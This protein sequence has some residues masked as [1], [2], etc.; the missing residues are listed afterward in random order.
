ME[1]VRLPSSHVRAR[2][3]RLWIEVRGRGRPRTGLVGHL[4]TAIDV[5]IPDPEATSPEGFEPWAVC[6]VHEGALLVLPSAAAPALCEADVA[7]SRGRAVVVAA[8]VVAISLLAPPAQASPRGTTDGGGTTAV[9]ASSSPEHVEAP[10]ETSEPEPSTASPNTPT[11]GDQAPASAATP[12][13]SGGTAAVPDAAL[14]NLVGHDVFATTAQGVVAGRIVAFDGTTVSLTLVNGQVAA[15]PRVQLFGVKLDI[16]SKGKQRDW[17]PG[18]G[19]EI[20]GG[21]LTTMGVGGLIAGFVLIGTSYSSVEY[22]L[23]AM[24]AGVASLG[25]GVPLLVVG[26]QKRKRALG[27]LK[28]K[29]ATLTPAPMRTRGGGWGGSLTLRF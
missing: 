2:D 6:P 8:A 19:M 9:T 3:G 26:V 10:T 21:V 12:A 28:G 22:I 4:V 20:A 11:W 18:T 25:A 17:L 15:I 7:F 24:G 16:D 23:P 29:H 13:P 14:A 27:K 1:A 5:R